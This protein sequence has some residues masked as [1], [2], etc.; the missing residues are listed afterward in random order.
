VQ[1]GSDTRPLGYPE[2]GYKEQF[3]NVGAGKGLV[4]YFNEK[5]RHERDVK[6]DTF[7]I[8]KFTSKNMDSINMYRSQNGNLSNVCDYL[9]G[10]INMDKTTVITGDF[11]L[12][13]VTKGNNKITSFLKALGFKQYVIG[14]THIAGGHLD[15]LYMR[16]GADQAVTINAE[17]YSPYYSDHDG[18]LT[19]V[20]FTD[21]E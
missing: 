2:K 6:T 11:N 10:L 19:T 5:F 14:P 16:Q 17:R 21:Q 12:C 9:T 3:I 1:D 13:S 15:H 18:V 7:Q 8:T 4:T 20:S